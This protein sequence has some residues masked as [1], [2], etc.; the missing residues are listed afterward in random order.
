LRP[1]P[2]AQQAILTKVRKNCRDILRGDN[3]QLFI[4]IIAFIDLIKANTMAL[5]MLLC[6]AGEALADGRCIPTTYAEQQ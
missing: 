2:G 4:N 3:D 6:R 1:H 5:G